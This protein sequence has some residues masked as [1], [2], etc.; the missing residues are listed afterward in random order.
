MRRDANAVPFSGFARVWLLEPEALSGW[1]RSAWRS[2]PIPRSIRSSSIIRHFARAW[3]A[4]P[5]NRARERQ[6]PTLLDEVSE[7]TGGLHFHVGNRSQR[8]KRS[9]K[10][11]MRF[12]TNT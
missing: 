11:A 12:A 8:K 9:S 6:E 2:K 7:K 10:P 4:K 3:V 1:S 5:I